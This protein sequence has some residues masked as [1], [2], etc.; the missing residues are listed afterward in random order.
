MRL[1]LLSKYFAA[2]NPHQFY[3]MISC[4]DWPLNGHDFVTT[5]GLYIHVLVVYQYYPEKVNA[6]PEFV[7]LMLAAAPEMG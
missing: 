4:I 3:P 5:Y 6:K 1:L 2:I 7:F